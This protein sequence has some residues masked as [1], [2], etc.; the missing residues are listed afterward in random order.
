VAS[1]VVVA[2]AAGSVMTSGSG[3]V[4]GGTVPAAHRGERAACAKVPRPNGRP[5]QGLC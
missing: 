2:A 5:H 1:V 4:A 3:S